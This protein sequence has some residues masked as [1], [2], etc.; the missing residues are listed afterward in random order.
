MTQ[1]SNEL[2]ARE[3]EIYTANLGTWAIFSGRPA[4]TRKNNNV[5]LIVWENP[6]SS[7]LHIDFEF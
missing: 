6:L 3:R 2:N 1:N 4:D 7:S 5:L